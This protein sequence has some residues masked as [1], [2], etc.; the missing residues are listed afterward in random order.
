MMDAAAQFG[1]GGLDAKSH[2]MILSERENHV[3]SNIALFFGIVTAST[4]TKSG[5]QGVLPKPLSALRMMTTEDEGLSFFG[6]NG[7]LIKFAS[8]RAAGMELRALVGRQAAAILFA[9]LA[10]RGGAAAPIAIAGAIAPFAPGLGAPEIAVE[11]IAP[12]E[13]PPRSGPPP[14]PPS[15]AA[16]ADSTIMN[17]T[18]SSELDAARFGRFPPRPPRASRH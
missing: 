9:L 10:V 18:E 2:R 17:I 5:R 11:P 4:H 6:P 14:P 7:V 15:S 3:L 12:D 8:M 16:A 13:P 1:L